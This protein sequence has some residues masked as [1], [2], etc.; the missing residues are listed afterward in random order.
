[1]EKKVAKKQP[2]KKVAKKP[3]V[4]LNIWQKLLAAQGEVGTVLKLGYNDYHKYSY[5]TERDMLAEIKPTLQKYGL[6]VLPETASKEVQELPSANIAYMGVKFN[7]I[8]VEN[9]SEVY[10]PIF[11]GAGKDEQD[12]H[13]P[14]AYT[15]AVKYFLAKTFLIET[16]DDAEKD[17]S[18]SKG[19]SK[20]NPDVKEPKETADALFAKA[21]IMV[22]NSKNAVGLIDYSQRLK[23][24]KTFSKQQVEELNRLI[25]ARVD[26]LDN[27]KK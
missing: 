9:P 24:S 25:S 14:K 23:D 19:K 21:K 17:D 2:R 18:K 16:D 27:E 7:I 1:M 22:E 20:A 8:N 5:F 11:Y 10:S 12:K 26:Q 3:A 6:L 13:V 15:M 4:K